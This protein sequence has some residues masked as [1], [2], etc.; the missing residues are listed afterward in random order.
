MI[1]HERSQ[2]LGHFAN[3][4]VEFR[5]SRIAPDQPS[6]ESLDLGLNRC[7]HRALLEFLGIPGRTLSSPGRVVTGS[8]CERFGYDRMNDSSSGN[9]DRPRQRGVG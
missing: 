9:V 5:F 7:S 6:H 3:G 8:L 4:L 2:A 1:Q